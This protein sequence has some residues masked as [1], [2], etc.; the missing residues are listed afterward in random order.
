MHW[1]L[2]LDYLLLDSARNLGPFISRWEIIKFENC[3]YKRVGILEV[4]KLL[5]QRFL[6]FSSS[7]RDMSGPILG[8]LSSNRWSGCMFL[9]SSI[10]WLLFAFKFWCV[11][12][13]QL[14]LACVN[15]DEMHTNWESEPDHQV[16]LGGW[17]RAKL[18]PARRTVRV[19]VGPARGG[20]LRR[21][22]RREQGR[23]SGRVPGVR[24][25]SPRRQGPAFAQARSPVAHAGQGLFLLARQGWA[26]RRRLRDACRRDGVFV[27]ARGGRGRGELPRKVFGERG[28]T[29]VGWWEPEGSQCCRQGTGQVSWHWTYVHQILEM[30]KFLINSKQVRNVQLILTLGWKIRGLLKIMK[31]EEELV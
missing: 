23:P 9:F 2:S 4:L 20:S 17:I 10:P 24:P 28:H 18:Q 15:P 8:D 27:A 5:F 25:G 30:F 22:A 3:W 6:N 29:F 1:R 11:Y 7:Q 14:C 12:G 26:S 19:S 16:F 21:L 13:R 31:N